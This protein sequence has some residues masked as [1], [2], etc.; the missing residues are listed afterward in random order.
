[1]TDTWKNKLYFVDNLVIMRERIADKIAALITLQEPTGPMKT[2][3][4]TAGFYETTI[5]ISGRT[6][7]YPKIQILTIE[8]LLNGKDLQYPEWSLDA[9]HKKAGRKSKK[10]ADEQISFL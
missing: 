5:E 7:T 4:A 9:T 2:E 10:K 3:A 6:M 1:M 8:E